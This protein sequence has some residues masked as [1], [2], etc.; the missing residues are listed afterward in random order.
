MYKAEAN[1]QVLIIGIIVVVLITA[2]AVL[3]SLSSREQAV[4]QALATLA[5]DQTSCQSVSG[6]SWIST[7]VNNPDGTQLQP[8][9]VSGYSACCPSSNPCARQGLCY[10]PAEITDNQN[11]PGNLQNML[12]S[13]QGAWFLCRSSFTGFVI[14]GNACD[15][16][17]WLPCTTPL[18]GVSLGS[19]TYCDGTEWKTQGEIVQRRIV[20]ADGTA[21]A[22]VF[23]PLRGFCSVASNCIAAQ[24][25]NV[26]VCYADHSLTTS[27]Q[28]L[29]LSNT[30][31]DCNVEGAIRD[32]RYICLIPSG[33]ASGIWQD[34]LTC[35]LEGDV[36]GQAICQRGRWTSCNSRGTENIACVNNRAELCTAA[37]NAQILS[38]STGLNEYYCN[39]PTATSGQTAPL[40]QWVQCNQQRLGE[41][42]D[43]HPVL[44]NQN[45]AI[46]Y[47]NNYVCSNGGTSTNPLYSWERIDCSSCA[48]AA[49]GFCTGSSVF[50]LD[51]NMLQPNY[52]DPFVMSSLV[53]CTLNQN[54]CFLFDGDPTTPDFIPFDQDTVDSSN[55]I[56][57]V[58]GNNNNWLRCDPQFTSSVFIAS[59]GNQWLCDANQGSWMECDS[60][61]NSQQN[62]NYE[63]RN[64]AGRWEWF[65]VFACNSRSKYV[66]R[67]SDTQIC[68]GNQFVDCANVATDTTLHDNANVDVSCDTATGRITVQELACFDNQDNDQ[69]GNLDCADSDC[70]AS[71]GVIINENSTLA[72]QLAANTCPGLNYNILTQPLGPP[73]VVSSYDGLHICSNDLPQFVDAVQLCSLQTPQ[74]FTVNSIASMARSNQ[75]PVANPSVISAVT[76]YRDVVMVYEEPA[77]T[78][79]KKVSVVLALDISQQPAI[80]DLNNLITNLL[81]GQG[82]VLRLGG[83]FYLLTYPVSQTTFSLAN[84]ELRH[85]PLTVLYTA[86]SYTGTN[87]YIFNVLGQRQVVLAQQ[88]SS[89]VISS[90]SPGE[91][92]A[93]YVTPLNLSQQYEATVTS[94]TP[95]N[96]ISSS[97]GVF[98]ICRSDNPNDI[99]QVQLC[100]ENTPLGVLKLGNL[101]EMTLLPGNG[102]AIITS[103]SGSSSL[104]FP[105]P[106]PGLSSIFASLGGASPVS[107]VL[108]SPNSQPFDTTY[109]LLYFYD[110][111]ANKKKVSLF[112]LAHPD[113][114]PGDNVAKDL[115]YNDFINN[116]VAGRRLGVEYEGQHYLLGHNGTAPISLPKL[117][118]SSYVNGQRTIFPAIG[119]EDNVDFSILGGARINLQR[120]YGFPPPPFSLSGLTNAEVLNTP[121][122]LDQ[123]LST[124]MSSEGPVSISGPHNYG[125]LQ[126]SAN[127]LVSLQGEFLLSSATPLAVVNPLFQRLI[128]RQPLRRT[129]ENVLFYYRSAQPLGTVQNPR[130]LKTVALYRV[131]DVIAAGS[132]TPF[133]NQF[134]QTFTSGKE[135]ALA[136]GNSYYLLS[137]QGA[138]GNAP[139]FFT[140]DN[141]HLTTLDKSR[142]FAVAVI[143]NEATFTVPEGLLKIELRLQPG[144]N[145]IVFRTTTAL[146]QLSAQQLAPEAYAQQLTAVNKISLDSGSANQLD[147]D[148]CNEALYSSYATADVCFSTLSSAVARDDDGQTHIVV[149]VNSP[150]LFT[151]NRVNYLLEVNGQTGANKIVT[152]RK[153]IWINSLMPTYYEANWVNFVANLTANLAPLFNVSNT[154]Y[155]PLASSPLLN[156]QF[157]FRAYPNGATYNL[158]NVNA[159]STVISNGTLTLGDDILR[160][161]QELTGSLRNQ[162]VG[163]NFVLEPYPYLPDDGSTVLFN[164]TNFPD[165]FIFT[166]VIDGLLYRLT[167]DLGLPQFT[168]INLEEING[169]SATSVRSIMVNRLLAEGDSRV[170]RV[171][172]ERFEIKVEVIHR[173]TPLS[174]PDFVQVAV[175][176]R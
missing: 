131:F 1:K 139:Q 51:N 26:D 98:S 121:I 137:Y 54:D 120:R 161:K 125:V 138:G 152:L 85:L 91:A 124:V 106:A 173:D 93:A 115:N 48:A 155:L 33:S 89:L 97:L 64:V 144:N 86:Q 36:R 2:V 19:R 29:C 12:C 22:T 171:G 15:G 133:T 45:L 66:L 17:R 96:L 58:C 6:A 141:L 140:M 129:G 94:S 8:G 109:S 100:L 159:I 110:S 67:N 11:P 134:I 44:N 118:L 20:S 7:A 166:P 99:Q 41:G 61:R 157:S 9:T 75:R 77:G 148:I 82:V 10:V 30:W 170:V 73:V 150:Q 123:E 60:S 143:G 175:R 135:L 142:S 132:A 3:F 156:Q 147:L 103:P 102:A 39:A 88:G 154:L 52:Y 69:D 57:L 31:Y 136:F 80:F 25:G 78:Q 13:Q 40:P 168:T 27:G 65:S 76:P 108:S 149:D 83:E 116:M 172:A 70:S 176:R 167:V 164:V 59:D 87:S 101:T 68:N 21:H 92:P 38:S 16:S 165:S 162:A 111:Q 145:Q 28:Y 126:Q 56:Q 4:G 74:G 104:L 151:V 43:N 146:E 114:F 153:I 37:R 95:V 130:W 53:G 174:V 47:A 71:Q 107:V 42:V 62:G 50:K 90:I 55:G 34:G 23:S 35:N 128:Y 117:D 24:A 72:I 84:L 79:P 119:S 63:C 112:M 49:P 32:N 127:D 18:T 105:S 14:E 158:R 163:A 169:L 122:D 160:I 5:P 81:A 113:V 46:Q